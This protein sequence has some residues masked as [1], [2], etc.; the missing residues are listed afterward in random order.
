MKKIF[1]FLAVFATIAVACERVEIEPRD[2]EESAKGVK[3]ITETV[4]GGQEIATKVTIDADAKF[5]W[6]IGDNVAVHVSNGESHKYVCTSGAGG[7]SAAAATASFTVSYPEGYARDAFAVFPSTIVTEDAANYGQG[8]Q[9]LDV[10]LP[11]SYTLAEVSGE[12][13]PC[14]MIADNTGS[15]WEFKHLCGMLRLTVNGIPSDATG[16]IIQFPGKKVNGAFSIASPVTLESSTIATGVPA[17][18]EDKITVTFDAGLTSAIVNIPLPTGDYEDLF[19]T[20]VG[21]ATKVAAVRHIKAG[22]YT[23]TRARAK[24][25]TT[26]MVSFSVS[27][28]KTVFFSPGNLVK[29]DATYTVG[30]GDERYAFES[31]P[32]STNGGSLGYNEG[33]PTSTSSRGYFTW[34]EIATSNEN[35]RPFTVN[36]VSGWKAMSFDEWN[37][38][39][40]DGRTM[41]DGVRRCY[42]V[43][44]GSDGTQI[45]LLLPPDEATAIDVVDLDED[46]DYLTEN[47]NLEI[48]ISKG[49]VFLP[50]SGYCSVGYMG[51]F[52]DEAGDNGYYWYTTEDEV[53]ADNAYFLNF[54]DCGLSDSGTE[55]KTGRSYYSIRLV[56]E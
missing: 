45:G 34:N 32:F 56:H 2:D 29:T 22:G 46:P 47:I 11:A 37:Y 49:F 13:S 19:I 28:T 54:Y 42:I 53:E 30:S 6:T 8:S 36:G 21:T 20:P 25:L 18:G 10:T 26:T 43:D 9:T 24:K 44:L 7:A 27:D 14:P 52:W 40:F 33:T 48:Y 5:A 4:T 16:L 35:P 55:K 15:S 39:Y 51:T 41:N 1:L 17:D 31:S 23:A 3:M 50:A 12:T 38:L